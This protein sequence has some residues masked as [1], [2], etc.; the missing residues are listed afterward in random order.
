MG[1]QWLSG[2]RK[3]GEWTQVMGPLCQ[4]YSTSLKLLPGA[5]ISHRDPFEE[6]CSARHLVSRAAR[7]RGKH[8]V[9]VTIENASSCTGSFRTHNTQSTESD[10]PCIPMYILSILICTVREIK[11]NVSQ[12]IVLYA[13]ESMP[14]LPGWSNDSGR[15]WSMDACTLPAIIA[16]DPLCFGWGFGPELQTW[17][18]FVRPVVKQRCPEMGLSD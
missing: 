4:N 16:H 12:S 15:F 6:N 14:K 11:I 8:A 1:Q 13:E 17:Q 9:C 5:I 10:I 18:M 2:G 3:K 7:R